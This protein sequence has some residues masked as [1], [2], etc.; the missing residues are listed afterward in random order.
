[1]TDEHANLTKQ[2]ERLLKGFEGDRAKVHQGEYTHEAILHILKRLGPPT[3]EEAADIGIAE[4][5][6]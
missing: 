5:R 1:M 6:A 4:E 3:A 2:F